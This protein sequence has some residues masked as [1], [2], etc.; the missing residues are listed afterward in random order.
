MLED[1]PRQAITL[2]ISALMAAAHLS[3][4]VPGERKAEAVQVALEGPISTDCPA[5]VLRTHPD[6]LLFLDEASA[7]KLS[8]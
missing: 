4:V 5:S 2:T 8:L 3:I 6:A 1:V 7:S